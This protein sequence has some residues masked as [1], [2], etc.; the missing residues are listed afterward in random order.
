MVDG[1]NGVNSTRQVHKV[2]LKTLVKMEGGIQVPFQISV[3]TD[4]QLTTLT[5]FYSFKWRVL[6]IDETIIV[7]LRLAYAKGSSQIKGRSEIQVN[8]QIIGDVGNGASL[9][10]AL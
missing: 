1:L 9:I 2:F 4:C 3:F 7:C 10:I 8:A 5:L 6:G